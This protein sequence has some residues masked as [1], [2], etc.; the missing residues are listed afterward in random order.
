MYQKNHKMFTIRAKGRTVKF[1]SGLLTIKIIK[2]LLLFIQLYSETVDGK[3]FPVTQNKVI[4][5]KP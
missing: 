1:R 3:I 4:Y 5:C 2:R